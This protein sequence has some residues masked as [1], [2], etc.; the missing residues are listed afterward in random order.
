MAEGDRYFV[1]VTARAEDAM[2][3]LARRGLDL[4]APT[5]HAT[6]DGEFEIEGL[7]TLEEV[8]A[9]VQDGYRVSVDATVASRSR[10][11]TETTTLDEWLQAM[12]Q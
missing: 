6:K 4:F 1:R 10:A 5:A 11:A 3:G 7:L 2:K 12:G 9:L 8:G